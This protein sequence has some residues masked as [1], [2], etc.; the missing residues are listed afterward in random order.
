MRV[1]AR[2]WRRNMW[3]YHR[4]I[5]C[6]TSHT[7]AHYIVEWHTLISIFAGVDGIHQLS[8]ITIQDCLEL[9]NKIKSLKVKFESTPL[10]IRLS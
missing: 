6:G 9:D 10:G 4:Y 8:L 5:P 2:I 1:V 7:F 3:L